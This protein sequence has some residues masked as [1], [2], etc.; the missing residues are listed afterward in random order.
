MRIIRRFQR[1]K[2]EEIGNKANERIFAPELRLIDEKGEHLGVFSK[3]EALRL[4]REKGLDL[5]EISPK[6]NP[7][8]AKF[9]D[10]GKFKYEKEKEMRKQK[11]HAKQVE[12]KGVR[13]SLKISIGDI[14]VREGQAIKFLEAGDKARIEMILRGR[15]RAHGALAAEI[16]NNFVKNLGEKIKIRTEQ[17]LTRQDG[18]LMTIIT[19]M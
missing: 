19:K 14:S 7:P 11:A 12:V 8:I 1:P 3:E 6:E 17:P 18:K 4:A 9:L 2:K 15:E 13:L 16:I 10:F 5:V